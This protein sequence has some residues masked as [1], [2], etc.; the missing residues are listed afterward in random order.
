MWIYIHRVGRTARLKRSEKALMMLSA[1]EIPFIQKLL[2]RKVPIEKI[3][4][5]N[6]K[7]GSIK[8]QL[9]GM[10]FKDPKLK[11][12]RQKVVSQ[13]NLCCSIGIHMLHKVDLPPE[14]KEGV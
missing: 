1:S 2:A 14:R 5:K 13:I 10:C 9:S 12:L 7:T 4:V 11:Y 8:Q 6:G 3:S